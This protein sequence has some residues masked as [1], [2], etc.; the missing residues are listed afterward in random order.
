MFDLRIVNSGKDGF[1]TVAPTPVLFRLIMDDYNG[2]ITPHLQ[3]STTNGEDWSD[4]LWIKQRGD[5]LMLE[6]DTAGGLGSAF[7]RNEDDGLLEVIR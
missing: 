1:D 3:A 6:V 5:K 7:L 4:L 2:D